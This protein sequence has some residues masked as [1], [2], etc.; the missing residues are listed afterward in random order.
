MSVLSNFWSLFAGSPKTTNNKAKLDKDVESYANIGKETRKQIAYHFLNGT[1]IP[2]LIKT[3]QTGIIGAGITIQSRTENQDIDN[4]F[5]KIIREHSKKKN[6]EVT[7]RYSLN[8][9][10]EIAISEKFRK[11]GVLVR[12]RYN[13]AWKI[14]YK[15]E[16]IGID[17]IDVGKFNQ[18]ERIIN[19]LRKNKD[20]EIVGYFVF[21][22]STNSSS[23]EISAKDISSYMD[24]WMDISQYTAVARLSQLLPELDDLILYQKNELLAATDR[25]QGSVFWHTKMYDTVIDAMNELYKSLKAGNANVTSDNFAELTEIQRSITKKMAAE[26]IVPSGG[27]RAIPADDTIT[28][29]DNKTSSVYE[30]FNENISNKLTASQNRSRVI[31]YKNMRNTNW[32]TINALS[33]ID[34]AENATEM[35][36][37][38]EDIL[39]DWLERLFR[40]SV[41]TGKIPN[42]SWEEYQKNEIEYHNW[43]I[44]RNS[45]VVVDE[46]KLAISNEKNLKNRLTTEEEIYAK[47]NKDYKTEIIKKVKTD[48]ELK[49]QIKEEYKK[50]QL[51]IPEEYG[52]NP[53]QQQGVNNNA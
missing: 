38:T 10:L 47:R 33:S 3:A 36:K 19:G 34:E 45:R 15:I 52:I 40:I 24:Y 11:G 9:A 48:I 21:T 51:P 46:T 32:A 22:D 6:F 1:D 50:A 12:H 25:S 17:R 28:Q 30:P 31:T 39:D 53:I 44:L 8:G 23:I 26:G 14:P 2:A 42:L 43:E 35:R 20:G 37:I 41:Q 18:Q 16:L 13:A 7:G 27:V 4:S 5:E 29:I 49:T